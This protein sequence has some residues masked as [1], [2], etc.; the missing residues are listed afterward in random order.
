VVTLGA[1][2]WRNRGGAGVAFAAGLLL[3][4]FEKMRAV[5]L[6]F[7]PDHVLSASYALPQ[8]QYATQSAVNEFSNELVRR[9]RQVP[10]VTSAGM[11][12]FLPASGNVNNNAFTA[13]GYVPPQGANMSLAT[14]VTVSGDYLQTMGIPLL[15]GRAFNQADKANAQLVTIVNHKLAEHYW[16]GLDPIG[17]RLRLGTSEMK[18][19]WLTVVGVVADVKEGSPDV[20]PRNR[21]ISLW[22]N[23]KSLSARWPHRRIRRRVIMATSQ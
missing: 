11:T 18:T 14:F 1:C 12:S 23:S 8:K 2:G 4:S 20:P 6:G 7:R 9:L 15:G 10:G 19:P 3:R 21:A 22:N 17:K 16:H 13:E 5:N